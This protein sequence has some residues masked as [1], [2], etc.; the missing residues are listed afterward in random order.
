MQNMNIPFFI[1]AL[2][3]IVGIILAIVEIKTRISSIK[4]DKTPL[5]VG[6]IRLDKENVDMPDPQFSCPFCNSVLTYHTSTQTKINNV[7]KCGT[8]IDKN[9]G[10]IKISK[11]ALCISLETDHGGYRRRSQTS[12]DKTVFQQL[13]KI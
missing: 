4:R 10:T 8:V 3:A 2:L 7:F 6:G 13:R 12:P 11:T 9:D 5:P 1:S